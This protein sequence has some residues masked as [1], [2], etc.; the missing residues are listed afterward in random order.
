MKCEYFLQAIPNHPH[1]RANGVTVGTPKHGQQLF[2]DL[3]C[4]YT[5]CDLAALLLHLEK[6]MFENG[7]FGPWAPMGDQMHLLNK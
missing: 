4:I 2:W 1:E 3:Y 6:I 7:H 5:H